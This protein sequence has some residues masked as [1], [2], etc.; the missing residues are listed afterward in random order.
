M[1]TYKTYVFIILF[2]VIVVGIVSVVARY[3]KEIR[4]AQVRVDSLG[5][6]VIETDCGMIEYARV[7]DGYPVLV[8]HGAFGGFD[9]GLFASQY[10]TEKGFQVIAVSRYGY[11]RSPL[12]ENATLDMQ[13][14]LFACLLDKLG[15]QQTAVLGVSSGATSAIRFVARYPER[16][17]ALILQVP[18][19]PGKTLAAEPPKAAFTFMRSNFIYWVIVTYFE[20]VAQRFIG[21]PEGFKLTPETEAVL[22]DL[23]ATTLPSSGRIDGFVNDFQIH[24]SAFSEE[25][26]ETNP[27]SVYKIE[28]PVLAIMVLDD[29]IAL[30]ENVRSLAEKFPNARLFM[31]PDGGHPFLAHSA[32]V[33]T[34]IIRFLK[35]NVNELTSDN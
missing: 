17:S 33:N 3:F 21:V 11:L 31:V 6:Q 35:N 22:A 19:A 14:D 9:Q 13:V 24:T 20:P 25:I 23:L 15:I 2:G 7:G 34:E 5:S 27:Y 18:A 29:P 16:V 10:L 8:V 26:S 30:P 12:P 4:A 32:E 1:S 28:T